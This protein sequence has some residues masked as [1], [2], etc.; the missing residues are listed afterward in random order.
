M[1]VGAGQGVGNDL[2]REPGIADFRQGQA[3]AVQGDGAAQDKE[4]FPFAFRERKNEARV[5]VAF[6][7]GARTDGAVD[8]DADQVAAQQ[9]GGG[10]GELDI[11]ERAGG[12]VP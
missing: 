4:F 9:T 6:V 12:Q 3:D 1:Q 2:H 10:H 5:L 7:D 11:Q 8:V